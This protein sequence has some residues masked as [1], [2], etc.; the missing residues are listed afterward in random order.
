MARPS[1][2]VARPQVQRPVN[3]T[4]SISPGNLQ[5]PA[6]GG[7]KPNVT[8]PAPNANLKLP[9]NAQIPNQVPKNRPEVTRPGNVPQGGAGKLPNLGAGKLPDIGK[10]NL[11][12][13]K[14]KADLG[15]LQKNNPGLFDRPKDGGAIAGK[16]PSKNDVST[17]L[18][19]PKDSPGF[20]TT[21]PIDR[22]GRDKINNDFN[23]SWKKAIGGNNVNI[24]NKKI[25]DINV[26]LSKNNNYV[27]LSRHAN[28]IHNNLRPVQNNWFNQNW[29]SNNRY[30]WPRWHYHYFPRPPAY[31]WRP[32][33]WGALTAFMAGAAW[34]PPV[35]YDYGSNVVIGQDVVYVNDQPVA[36]AP[37][38][39]Q[40][41]IDLANVA[42][43]PADAQ[44]DWMPLG[45]FALSSN[46]DD[47]NPSTILQLALS[48]D[49][50]VSGVW[51]N[52]ATGATSDVEG[53]VNAE[54]QRLALRKPDQ[55]DVV[56]EVGVY[57]L[58]QIATPCLIHFGTMQTQTWYLT[59]LEAQE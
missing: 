53:R 38:Y 11:P 36:S 22:A 32:C 21:R 28:V 8:R 3:A 59:R 1:A 42:P 37:V 18:G 58:T 4:P 34:S 15:N 7:A 27:N 55:P 10:G 56:L 41:A 44:I 29:W 47:D 51:F 24:G 50:L 45:T 35:Y 17:W 23:N 14:G 49:G 48:K 39:A 16:G 52:R 9:G 30:N 33:T 19:Y 12:A 31:W 54:T 5:R 25:G 40:E 43:P 20:P 46:K 26:D 6:G 57:N 2:P 13:V